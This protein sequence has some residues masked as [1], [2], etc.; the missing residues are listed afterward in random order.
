MDGDLS[1]LD[2]AKQL[3]TAVCINFVIGQDV[4]I[5]LLFEFRFA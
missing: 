4:L 1:G 2:N 5:L 3:I